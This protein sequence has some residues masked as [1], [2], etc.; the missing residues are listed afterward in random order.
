M[1]S[2]MIIYLFILIYLYYNK[3]KNISLYFYTRTNKFILFIVL[4]LYLFIES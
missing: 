1:K 4:L 2:K 3:C